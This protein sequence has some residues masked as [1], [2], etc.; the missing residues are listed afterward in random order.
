[1]INNNF[2]TQSNIKNNNRI[3]YFDYLRIMATIAVIVLHI[4]A[5]NWHLTDVNSFEWKTFNFFDSLTRWGVPVFLMIS[6]G[7]FIEKSVEI[8][9]IYSKYVLRLAV[10]FLTWSFIYSLLAS[11]ITISERVALIFSGHYHMWFILMIIGIY[12]CLPIIKSIATN[13]QT[14]KYYLILSTI[15]TFIIPQFL[16]LLNDFGG[17][18]LISLKL[19]LENIINSLKI[20]II[21]GYVTYFLLGFYLNKINFTKKQRY[22]VYL[23]GFIGTFATIYLDLIVALKTQQACSNY[24]DIFNFTVM[25]QAIA[26]FTLF[27]TIKFKSR[28]FIVK[29]S[30]YSFGAYLVH[31]FIIYKLDSIFALNTLS[32]N[33]I[34]SITCIATITTIVSFT[35]SA[36]INHIP[37]LKKYVV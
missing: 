33:P 23:F 30:K 25:L 4:S 3:I 19:I 18:K 21:V 2:N 8:K 29:L 37:I 7:L 36:L 12:M 27:K 11:N 6:G 22:V 24:Y 5:Q 20:N 35:I 16:L 31:V 9:Q 1:M 15:F 17:E 32:Y 10:S 34:L 26:I 14:L 28:N 13:S